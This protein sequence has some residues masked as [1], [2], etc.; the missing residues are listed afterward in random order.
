[1]GTMGQN[2]ILH[3]SGI[4]MVIMAVHLV[5]IHLLTIMLLIHL[6]LLIRMVTF[7]AILLSILLNLKGLISTW[8]WLYT[9][10]TNKSKKMFQSG[11]IKF[12]INYY[13]SDN[14]RSILGRKKLMKYSQEKY[15][16]GSW[17]LY[18]VSKIIKFISYENFRMDF[19]PHCSPSSHK[20]L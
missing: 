4:V 11:M 14:Q 16:K 1:M 20:T 9:N 13:K 19:N 6:L 17:K 8:L 10:I 15:K 12:L 3:L 2:T 18:R 5:V 7:M